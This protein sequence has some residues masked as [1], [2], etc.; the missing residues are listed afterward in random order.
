MFPLIHAIDNILIIMPCFF[1][2]LCPIHHIHPANYAHLQDHNYVFGTF[3]QPPRRGSSAQLLALNQA[4]SFSF[5]LLLLTFHSNAM[6]RITL[7]SPGIWS[8]LVGSCSFY[9]LSWT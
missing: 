9:R 3:H 4:L 8:V 5:I 1:C 2:F 6:A 7:Y